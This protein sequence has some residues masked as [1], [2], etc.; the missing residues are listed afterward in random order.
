MH[1]YSSGN[2]GLDFNMKRDTILIQAFL[3]IRIREYNL[4]K[5]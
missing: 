2:K 4:P 3:N 1:K 5:L